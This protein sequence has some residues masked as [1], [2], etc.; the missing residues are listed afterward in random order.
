MDL[1][2]IRVNTVCAEVINTPM[3]DQVFGEKKSQVIEQITAKLPVRRIGSPE[4][5]ADA[6]LFLMSNGFMTGTTLLIDD[7]DA[8]V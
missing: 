7:G 2:P 1:A 4:E 8:L 5:I 6:V 3:L